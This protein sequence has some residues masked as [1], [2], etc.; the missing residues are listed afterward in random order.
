MFNFF[1]K[2]SNSSD[3]S[4]L[5][6]PSKDYKLSD[7]EI[8]R[9][10]KFELEWEKK[11]NESSYIE[12]NPSGQR[13]NGIVEDLIYSRGIRSWKP[14]NEGKYLIEENSLKDEMLMVEQS[15]IDK[16][17]F[18]N[19][20]SFI[21][22]DSLSDFLTEDELKQVFDYYT[23]RYSGT[24]SK[25][26]KNLYIPHKCDFISLDKKIISIDKNIYYLDWKSKVYFG[27]RNDGYLENWE[28]DRMEPFNKEYTLNQLFRL[29]D[30]VSFEN[31]DDLYTPIYEHSDLNL[32]PTKWSKDSFFMSSFKSLISFSFRDRLIKRTTELYKNIEHEKKKN[33]EKET[34]EVEEIKQNVLWN[35]D[36]DNN[37]KLDV[38]ELNGYNDLLESMKKELQEKGEK[39]IHHLIKLKK[40]IVDKGDNLNSIYNLLKSVE[41]KEDLTFYKGVLNNEINTYQ[42]LIFHSMSM[43][44]F[45]VQGDKFS[46]YEIYELFDE[47][48][49]FDS[50][51]EKD[52]SFKLS[53][54]NSSVE[55]TNKLLKEKFD[56]LNTTIY[57]NSVETNKKL[58]KLTYTTQNSI[59]KLTS[60]MNS[61]LKSINSSIDTNNFLTIINTYQMYKINKNTKSL[62]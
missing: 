8:E 53:D 27:F 26:V 1:K 5:E 45:L 9:I 34:N 10:E 17:L 30:S 40:F 23:D 44:T 58:D 6:K 57:N 21:K 24:N 28:D 33:K 56:E 59:N 54:I 25:D 13:V 62:R 37:E 20:K 41:T 60:T 14:D 2:P 55:I 3:Y 39:Y 35:L 49:V 51:W 18:E 16:F 36:K 19:P 43:I 4:H 38:L 7:E 50:K 12:I 15:L 22:V 32:F 48:N 52:L 11:S 46:F 61:R 29:P 42:K 47:L 31:I